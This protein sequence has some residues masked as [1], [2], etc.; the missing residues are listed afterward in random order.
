MAGNWGRLLR[1][2]GP[3]NQNHLGGW[4][5]LR[6]NIFEQLRPNHL[7]SRMSASFMCPTRADADLYR[8]KNDLNFM[9]VL[10]EVEIVD[11]TLPRH[12]GALSFAEIANEPAFL[13]GTKLAAQKYWSGA[14][15]NPAFGWE[16]LTSSALRVV[17]C[18]E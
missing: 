5:L 2:Y 13:D 6:E 12:L 14:A 11:E 3:A 17:A 18:L 10:H 9:Q 16:L 7:P 1:R 15:G 4:V 8:A